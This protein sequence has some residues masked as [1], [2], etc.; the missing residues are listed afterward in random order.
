MR[1]DVTPNV[2]V[3]D[4]YYTL[5]CEACF[6]SEVYTAVKEGVFTKLVKRQ[7]QMV[8]VQQQFIQ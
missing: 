2:P 1:V 8:W 6:V 4:I 3:M 5:P 7:L